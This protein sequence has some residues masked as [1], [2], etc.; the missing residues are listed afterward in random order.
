MFLR[1]NLQALLQLV[2]DTEEDGLQLSEEAVRALGFV[3]STARTKSSPRE[4]TLLDLAMSV[5]THSGY[6]KV[7]CR[8][9]VSEDFI[10]FFFLDF[11]EF[12]SGAI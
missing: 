12:F 10:F 4:C 8:S 3:F 9:W 1:T 7:G 2:Q 11:E 6:S 5:S